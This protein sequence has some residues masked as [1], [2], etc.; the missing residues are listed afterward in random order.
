M[1]LS[2]FLNHF[3]CVLLFYIERGSPATRWTGSVLNSDKI[4]N[5][6]KTVFILNLKNTGYKKKAKEYKNKIYKKTKEK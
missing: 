5:N 1:E 6:E 3:L 4:V 2:A